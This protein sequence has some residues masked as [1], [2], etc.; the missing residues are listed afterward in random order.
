[1]DIRELMDSLNVEWKTEGHEHCR[2]GWM[3]IDCP[4]C[5]K[6]W[7]HFRLGIHLT[8]N[9]GNCWACGPHRLV[10]IL[11]EITGQSYKKLKELSKELEINPRDLRRDTERKTAGE[12]EI[13]KRAG[14]LLKPH[15]RYLRKRGF[16]WRELKET[17]GDIRGIGIDTRLSW[18]IWIP[19][20]FDNRI[21]SWTTRS[22]SD[23]HDERYISASP[24]Q[25]EIDHKKMLYGEWLC[26]H[27]I[28][29]TE[30]PI[31]AWAIGPGAVATLGTSFTQAQVY[32]MANYPIRVICF[33]NEPTAQRRARSLCDALMPFEGETINVRVG[34]RGDDPASCPKKDVQAIR[35]MIE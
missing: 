10:D 27:G 1:M 26:T 16:D 18:R 7:R 31:S 33:D 3:Q 5:S 28:A 21:V 8:R 22:I 12:V 11:Q 19:I 34:R 6:S 9:Y 23:E 15:C 24:Q 20:Y 29:I 35:R 13:P 32:R 25:E 30:G 17:W 4:F 2:R 14:R